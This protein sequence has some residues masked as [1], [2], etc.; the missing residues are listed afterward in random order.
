MSI[1]F[2]MFLVEQNCLWVKPPAAILPC[3]WRR[4]FAI[5]K[6]EVNM[7]TTETRD[8]EIQTKW[9]LRATTSSV[10]VPEF[11]CSYITTFVFVFLYLSIENSLFLGTLAY[12]DFSHVQLEEIWMFVHRAHHDHIH[13]YMCICRYAY[14]FSVPTEIWVLWQQGLFHVHYYIF[15]V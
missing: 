1:Y 15:R 10:L 4:P 2:Q 5:R 3:N 13:V 7:Q 12:M 14:F 8:G 9:I 6:N 11:P